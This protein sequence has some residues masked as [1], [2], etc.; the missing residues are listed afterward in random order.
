[1]IATHDLELAASWAT[2]VVVLDDGD[3][4]ADGPPSDVFA[5][6]A[7]LERANLHPPQ[8]VR[9]GT[10]LGLSPAPLTVEAFTDRLNTASPPDETSKP[11]VEEQ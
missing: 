5:D 3:I 1:M 8:V 9:L 2:R 11:T 6:L 7:A 10:E 4:I